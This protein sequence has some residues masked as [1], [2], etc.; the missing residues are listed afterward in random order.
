MY[1]ARIPCDSRSLFPYERNRSRN[2]KNTERAKQPLLLLTSA[3]LNH[4]CPALLVRWIH[5]RKASV[6]PPS[7]PPLFLTHSLCGSL[8]V[9]RYRSP[10]SSF[11][12]SYSRSPSLSLVPPD[13]SLLLVGN[14]RSSAAAATVAI[15]VLVGAKLPQFCTF[16]TAREKKR[17]IFGGNATILSAVVM[18]DQLVSTAAAR[19]TCPPRAL[20][21]ATGST[22]SRMSL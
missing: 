17:I 11:W 20:R 4:N 6:S 10:S 3:I 12:N 22:C 8:L 18:W 21:S 9:P 19:Y 16:Y 5:K 14:K 7:V 2:T 1:K 15:A 13:A